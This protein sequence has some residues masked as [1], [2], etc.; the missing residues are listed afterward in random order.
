MGK[1]LAGF[2]AASASAAP[3]ETAAF[4]LSLASSVL[5]L[6]SSSVQATASTAPISKT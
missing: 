2:T 1:K 3:S 5:W 4:V 6:S